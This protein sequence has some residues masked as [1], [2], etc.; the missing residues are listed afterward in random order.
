MNELL[1]QYIWTTVTDS[2]MFAHD[3]AACIVYN[4]EDGLYVDFWSLTPTGW[5][6]DTTMLAEMSR[7]YTRRLEH[8]A[9]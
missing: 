1:N 5:H 6:R 7:A 3:T 8:N 2:W 4:R 9:S